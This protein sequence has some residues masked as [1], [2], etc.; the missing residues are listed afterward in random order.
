VCHLNAT[1]G[2]MYVNGMDLNNPDRPYPPAFD[3][4]Q[5][6]ELCATVVYSLNTCGDSIYSHGE[7]S[8][9]KDGDPLASLWSE[10]QSECALMTPDPRPAQC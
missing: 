10:K 5:L 2:Y 8:Q 4:L 6:T 7:Q 9:P 3:S 1:F